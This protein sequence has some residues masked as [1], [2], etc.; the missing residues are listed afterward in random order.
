MLWP[1]FLD[2]H[3]HA[4]TQSCSPPL[5]SCGSC[6]PTEYPLLYR[7]AH[8]VGL[9]RLLSSLPMMPPVL[10]PLA[11][12]SHFCYFQSSEWPVG[13]RPV[14][15]LDYSAPALIGTMCTR[16]H[17]NTHSDCCIISAKTLGSVLALQHFSWFP[18]AG[19][20]VILPAQAHL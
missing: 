1:W 11:G 17:T 13:C 4:V 20:S 9:M 12:S 16:T 19:T 18:I 10:W 5:S 14:T 6:K 3:Y 15:R 2:W 8:A 7:G